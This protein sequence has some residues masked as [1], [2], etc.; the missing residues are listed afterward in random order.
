MNIGWTQDSPAS[1]TCRFGYPCNGA[2]PSVYANRAFIQWAGFTFGKA[3]S[4]YDIFPRPRFSYFSPANSFTGDEGLNLA[5]YTTQW[6]NGITSTISAEDPRRFAITQTDCALATAPATCAGTNVWVA[7]AQL[8]S[9]MANIRYPDI[10]SNFRIDQAWGSFQVMGALHDVSA[11]YYFSNCPTVGTDAD[12]RHELRLSRRQVGVGGRRGRHLQP[13]LHRQG[14]HHRLPSQLC[15]GRREVY[16]LGDDHRWCEPRGVRRR[17]PLGLG[18]AQD[19]VVRDNIPGLQPGGIE[20]TRPGARSRPTSTSGPRRSIPRFIAFD[21]NAT[22]TSYVCNNI[23]G[24]PPA[25][26]ESPRS[27]P[28]AFS[29]ASGGNAA[30]DRR[31]ALMT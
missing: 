30:S 17:R 5:A 31:L 18:F 7:G 3:Q 15:E 27:L 9:N 19:A 12:R 29:F 25:G 23:L 21:Y 26:E 2:G 22:A 28:A 13:A 4:F 11:A 10:V 16:Q 20:L 8:N 1:G 14:R 24:A 6:G